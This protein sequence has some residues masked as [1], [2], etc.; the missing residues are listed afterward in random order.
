MAL[1]IQDLL[2]FSYCTILLLFAG[3]VGWRHVQKSIEFSWH[4]SLVIGGLPL[5]YYVLDSIGVLVFAVTCVVVYESLPVPQLDVNSKAVLITG[6]DSGFGHA[7]AKY[8]DS[9]GFKVFAGCLFKGGEGEQQLIE[10]CS[11]RLTTLQLDVTKEEQIKEALEIIKEKLE[12]QGLWGVVNN[13]GIAGF[14][15]VELAPISLFQKVWDINCL[16]GIRIIKAFLPLIRK[17]KGRIVN[18]SSAAG[19]IHLPGGGTYCVSKA[20]IE[21][22]SDVLRQEMKPWGVNVSIIEPGGFLTSIAEG[23]KVRDMCA[24]LMANIDDETRTFY[25]VDGFSSLVEEKVKT[26]STMTEKVFAPDIT[27]VIN[28]ITDAL[29]SMQPK[30][31]YPVGRGAR[32][33][34]FEANHFPSVVSDFLFSLNPFDSSYVKPKVTR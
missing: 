24:D 22:L 32:I 28:V 15:N 34:T 1:V 18:M 21:M 12:G 2:D 6:C 23:T 33:F 11:T 26:N 4:L 30:C 16:G 3:I 8:L 29:L 7:T 19:R 14:G 25:D 20:G 31:R 17:A 13:A 5:C 9:I 10:S 27:P